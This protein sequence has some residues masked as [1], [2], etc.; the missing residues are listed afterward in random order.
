MLV[1]RIEHG[2]MHRTR[3]GRSYVSEP[4]TIVPSRSAVTK[5]FAKDKEPPV[6]WYWVIFLYIWHVYRLAGGTATTTLACAFPSQ[7]LHV[8]EH[9]QTV[10]ESVVE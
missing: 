10:M 9:D 1:R 5:S 2:V 6:C 8:R 3:I 4:L 7:F